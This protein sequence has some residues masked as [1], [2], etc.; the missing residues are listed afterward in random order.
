[1]TLQPPPVARVSDR[2][3]IV[4]KTMN[5]ADLTAPAAAP[6]VGALNDLIRSVAERG[7]CMSSWHG[8][9]PEP[10]S[11][12]TRLLRRPPPQ[13][14]LASRGPYYEP[15]PGAADDARLPW[16]LYWE[17]AWVMRHGPQLRPGLRLLDAGGASSLFSC[18]LASLGCEVHTVDLDRTLVHNSALLARTMRWPLHAYTMDLA[19]LE[20]PDAYFDHA[21][22]ICVFEHLDLP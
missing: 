9:L 7:V 20:F 17:I 2:C 5:R 13:V 15:L 14:G 1:M 19:T 12:W 8:S 16:Y 21:Y 4:N 22:S 6:I 11:L 3:A 10:P 18:Y